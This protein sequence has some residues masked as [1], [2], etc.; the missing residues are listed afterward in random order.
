MLNQQETREFLIKVAMPAYR[1]F[2]RENG[3]EFRLLDEPPEKLFDRARS[4]REFELH[5][6][7][8]ALFNRLQPSRHV[9]HNKVVKLDL[10]PWLPEFGYDA[11]P[12]DD[13]LRKHSELQERLAATEKRCQRFQ[14]AFAIAG[15]FLI[16]GIVSLFPQ[17]LCT[18]LNLMI[19]GFCLILAW[20]VGRQFLEQ[21]QYNREQQ[22]QRELQLRLERLRERVIAVQAQGE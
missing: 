2:C 16:I 4:R 5:E 21:R 9:F 6:E 3:L 8:M 11:E 15:Y 17:R 20:V 19:G 7:A 18:E 14:A 1:R 10:T 12:I 22:E 13:F